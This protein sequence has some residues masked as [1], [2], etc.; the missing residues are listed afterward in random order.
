MTDQGFPHIK[1]IKGKPNHYWGIQHGEEFRRGIQ[2]LVEIRKSLLFQKSPHLKGEFKIHAEKQFKETEKFSKNLASEITGIA[3][4]SE[5]LIEDIV[6]LNN[7]TDFRDIPSDGGCSTVGISG[8]NKV[9]GQTWDMHGSAKKYVSIIELPGEWVTYSLVGCLGMMGANKHSLFVGVNNLNTG[10]AKPGVIWPAFIR[11]CLKAKNMEQMISL[12]E[13]CNFT[14]GH[15]YLFSDGKR[16][17]NWEISPSK[18]ALTKLIKEDEEGLVFHT[19]HCIDKEMQRIEEK[20]SLNST[21]KER[22]LLLEKKLNSNLNKD[23]LKKILQDHESYPKSICSH[24]Q[25]DTQDPSMT[26]GGAVF[27]H[28]TKILQL[29]RGCPHEDNNYKE[30]AITL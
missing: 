10:K 7:Y 19:N 22:Y 24:Y 11:E 9:S 14:S 23:D 17:E 20:I 5:T 3:K 28:V 12:S 6:L 1:L 29:W 2:E 4:G 18:R 27:D 15:N 13:K 25:A 8:A 16:V 21:T 26:C 30:Q